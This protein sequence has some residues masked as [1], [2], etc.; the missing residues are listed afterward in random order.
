MIFLESPEWPKRN[1]RP[2]AIWLGLDPHRQE[3]LVFCFIRAFDI[4]S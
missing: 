1:P 4:P 2:S 3:A